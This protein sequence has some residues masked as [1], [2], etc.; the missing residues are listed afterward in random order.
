MEGDEGPFEIDQRVLAK[1]TACPSQRWEWKD[2][3]FKVPEQAGHGDKSLP[4][5]GGTLSGTD[6]GEFIGELTWHIDKVK[7]EMILKDNVT[8]ISRTEDGNAIALF[9]L[10]HMGFDYG[11]VLRLDRN[12]DG[13]FHLTGI[14]RLPAEGEGLVSLGRDLFA[15]RSAGRMVVFSSG[16]GILGLAKCE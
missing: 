8:A 12:S 2:S 14:A 10:A 16:L 4:L 11:Y 9:G 13:G 7:P 1:A 5:W 15:V 3:I 6:R